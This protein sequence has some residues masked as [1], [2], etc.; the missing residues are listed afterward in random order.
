MTD[1]EVDRK[2]ANISGSLKRGLKELRNDIRLD[3]LYQTLLLEKVFGRPEP[4]AAM[5]SWS[6]APEFAWW[7]YEHVVDEQPSNIIELGSGT[8]TVAI[9]AALKESGGGRFLSFEHDL[10]YFEKTKDLLEICQLESHVD[11]I[12]APLDESEIEGDKYNWYSLPYDFIDTVVGAEGIDLLLIDGPPAATNRH[13]RYPALVRLKGYC[14]ESTVI[15]LD[16][17]NRDEEREVLDRWN[18]MMGGEYSYRLL[19][20]IRHCPAL[21]LP[22]DHRFYK[23]DRQRLHVV[24]ETYSGLSKRCEELKGELA[25]LE[26]KAREDAIKYSELLDQH[27]AEKSFFESEI[28]KQK[29]SASLLKAELSAVKKRY[30][31]VYRSLVY[32]LGLSLYNQTRSVNRWPKIPFS[33]LRVFKR[34]KQKGTPEI[35]EFKEP[36]LSSSS[37]KACEVF[38]ES[39]LSDTLRATV[40]SLGKGSVLWGG[41]LI[42]AEQGHEAALAFVESRAKDSQALGVHLFRANTRLRSDK[43]WLSCVN[44]YIGFCNLAPVDLKPGNAARFSRLCVSEDLEKVDGPLISVIM[45]AYN[46]EKT[47]AHAMHS[48]LSQTWRNIELIVVD[49]CSDDLTW[50]R[51]VEVASRDDRVVALRN[52]ANVGP[53]V[54]KNLALRVARGEY[55]TGQDADDWAHPQRLERDVLHIL[56]SDNEVDAVLSTMIRMTEQ[57][58]FSHFAKVGRT[59]IDGARRVSSISLMIKAPYLRDVL[60]G[61]DSVR[62]G[63]DSEMIGRAEILMGSRFKRIDNIGMFCLDLDTSLTNDPEHGVSKVNGV[64]ATRKMFR[65]SYTK[66]HKNISEGN[67]RMPFPHLERKYPAPD[68]MLVRRESILKN[69]EM[70][71]HILTAN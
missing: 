17:S 1:K 45:P 42:A 20:H 16:D 43:E 25:A 65:E 22:N 53:Y 64:S 63:A 12:Y 50:D 9:A 41:S 37:D 19:S 18:E 7:L 56:S 23:K 68:A 39:A 3:N 33:I 69:I 70:H 8:S 60:G 31:L 46:A 62:F 14:N 32:Q 61:W 48:I 40:K 38:R 2:L 47:V 6:I 5:T 35:V 66:W 30:K 49:D 15:L 24:K 21:F 57:G 58:E 51:V 4:L 34:H 55:I 36:V 54:S 29:A 59:S 28:A 26:R 67:A 13:S 52:S 71:K 10:A 11:L 27:N 44:T